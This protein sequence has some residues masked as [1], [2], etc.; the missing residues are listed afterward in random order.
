MAIHVSVHATARLEGRI[1]DYVTTADL[2]V[3][4][5]CDNLTRGGETHVIIKRL[6][7]VVTCPDGS[8]G[9]LIVAA[10]HWDGRGDK[11]I[12]TLMFRGSWQKER[13]ARII[14]VSR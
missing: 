11:T 3:I 14:D 8:T 4:D 10:V 5:E 6:G 9:D 12:A 13:R 1:G 2:R 7:G